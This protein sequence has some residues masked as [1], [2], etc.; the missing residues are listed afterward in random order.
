MK[1]LLLSLIV[2]SGLVV[3][4]QDENMNGSNLNPNEITTQDRSFA[5]NASII[6]NSEIQ[7]GKLALIKAENPEI[8]EYAKMMV[9][10]HTTAQSNLHEIAFG[11]G[12]L[13]PD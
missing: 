13:T 11:A 3:S 12:I 8:R 2:V 5:N 7:L 6:N 1:N 10:E 4:C 9:D